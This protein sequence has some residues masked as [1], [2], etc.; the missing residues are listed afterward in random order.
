MWM[1]NSVG[2]NSL[3]CPPLGCETCG[4]ISAIRHV[5]RDINYSWVLTKRPCQIC[6]CFAGVIKLSLFE[7]YID[8]LNYLD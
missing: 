1:R 8:V 6:C 2:A 4:T 3:G 7:I 5:G